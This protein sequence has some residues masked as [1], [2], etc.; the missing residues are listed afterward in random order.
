MESTNP[1]PYQYILSIT[2]TTINSTTTKNVNVTNYT[3]DNSDLTSNNALQ[4]GNYTVSILASYNS[5]NT[6]ESSF[7]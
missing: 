5:S 4:P 6:I 7:N 3:L 2:N 1:T